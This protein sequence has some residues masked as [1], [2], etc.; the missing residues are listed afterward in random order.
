MDFVKPLQGFPSGRFA[1]R[2]VGVVRLNRF[3]VCGI[4]DA[5]CKPRADQRI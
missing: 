3:A 5:D 2:D 1:D 4:C